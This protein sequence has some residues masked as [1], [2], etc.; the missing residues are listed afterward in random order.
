MESVTMRRSSRF[1]LPSYVWHPEFD[2]PGAA[3]VFSALEAADDISYTEKYM[4]DDVTRDH[5][6]R[7]HFAAHRLASCKGLADQVRWEKVYFALRDRIILG[8]RKLIYRA[9]RRRM[10]MSNRTDDLIGDC[11][12]VMIQAVA[13]YNPWLGI[14]FSTYAYTCLVRALSRLA[15][16]LASDKLSHSLSLDTL[17]EGEPGRRFDIEP[18][19]SGTLRIDEYLRAEHPLLSEREKLIIARRFCLRDTEAMPTLEKVGYELG[20]SKERV[21]QVQASALTK[22]RKALVHMAPKP[23]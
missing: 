12:I 15:Q 10:A 3:K 9:V 6:R 20:L 19:S 14:R 22:L 11:H 7:M 17:P 18:T 4:P 16:R 2:E 13:A 23:A 5:T 1:G 8:N 21:R